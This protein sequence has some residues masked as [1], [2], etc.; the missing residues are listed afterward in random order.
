MTIDT[1]NCFSSNEII[2]CPILGTKDCIV[3]TNSSTIRNALKD[4]NSQPTFIRIPSKIN[5]YNVLEIGSQ[6]FHG[7]TS[8]TQIT[9]EEGIRQISHFAF[10]SLSSL[11]IIILP[12]TMTYLGNYSIS[13]CAWINN[14]IPSTS[15]GTLTIII[16]PNS[17]LNYLG[18]GAIERK[19]NVILYYCGYGTPQFISRPFYYVDNV[20]IYSFTNFL[21]NEN[22]TIVDHSFCPMLQ[23]MKYRTMS[24]KR[25]PLI[26]LTFFLILL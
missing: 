6:A 5:S 15:S 22:Q 17:K 16:H 3:G 7:V 19:S 8:I 20:T 26:S 12:S 2:F 23:K 21:M 24:S 18:I 14:E 4:T 1:E 25:Y 10:Y 9:I 13:A 11:E